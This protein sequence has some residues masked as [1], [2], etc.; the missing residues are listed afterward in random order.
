MKQLSSFIHSITTVLISNQIKLTD[1]LF[2]L[3]RYHLDL[4]KITLLRQKMKNVHFLNRKSFFYFG[5]HLNLLLDNINIHLQ[6]YSP[7]YINAKTVIDIGASFGTFSLMVNYLNPKA[8]IYSFEPSSESF[9]LLKKNCSGIKNIEI[10][11]KAAGDIDKKVNFFHD[12]VYPEGSQIRQSSNNSSYVVDQI[13]LDVFI[14]SKKLKK[15]SLLKIDTE[16]YELQVLNGAKKALSITEYLIIE[17]NIEKLSHLVDVLKYLNK[18]N[19]NLI[20][21]D[22]MNYDQKHIREIGSLDFFFKKR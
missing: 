7:Y 14:T 17:I 5:S 11:N 6:N 12:D 4:I 9:S 20:N 2:F 16:G 3:F 15:I 18:Y 1:K 19:F 22:V 21:L 10:I 8:Q 13:S